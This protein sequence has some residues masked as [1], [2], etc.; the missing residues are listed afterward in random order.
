MVLVLVLAAK[1]AK[2][3]LAML[4]QWSGEI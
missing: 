2:L 4:Q 1:A 3:V